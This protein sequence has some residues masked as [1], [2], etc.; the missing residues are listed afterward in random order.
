MNTIVNDSPPVPR[1]LPDRSLGWPPR[2]RLYVDAPDWVQQARG[3][4]DALPGRAG[5]GHRPVGSRTGSAAG[6]AAVVAG[7][8]YLV[9]TMTSPSRWR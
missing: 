6:R 3:T 8:L 7:L 9:Y 2:S 1:S 4:D 5:P